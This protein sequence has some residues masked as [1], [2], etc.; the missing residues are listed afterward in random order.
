MSRSTSF[1]KPSRARQSGTLPSSG[2]MM[3]L[4]GAAFENMDTIVRKHIKEPVKVFGVEADVEIACRFLQH[5]DQPDARYLA[6]TLFSA[7]LDQFPKCPRLHLLRAH[8]IAT[9]ELLPFDD[10]WHSLEAAKAMKPAF[11]TRF[12]IFFE[13][14]AMEQQRR[15]ED[16]LASTLNVAGYAEFNSMEADAQRYHLETIIAIK[17]LWQYMRNEK[18][19]SASL[20]FLLERIEKNR[21]MSIILYKKILSKYPRSKQ[22]LR[23]YSNFLLR[24][25][26]DTEQAKKLLGRAEEIENDEARYNSLA[27]ANDRREDEEA[28]ESI[29]PRVT[30]YAP[31]EEPRMEKS[32]TMS[33]D[34]DIAVGEDAGGRARRR[35]RESIGRDAIEGEIGGGMQRK[36]SFAHP[37]MYPIPQEQSQPEMQQPEVVR[38]KAGSVVPSSVS[39]QR[40]ARQQRF[41]KEAITRR[42]RAPIV[43]FHFIMNLGL[44]ALIAI[45]SVGFALGIIA[46]ENITSALDEAY[47]RCRPRVT[48]MRVNKAV[49]ELQSTVNRLLPTNDVESTYQTMLVAMSSIVQGIC[50]PILL[51][52]LQKYHLNDPASIVMTVYRGSTAT[53]ELYNPF[54]LGQALSDRA[55]NIMGADMSTIVESTDA[56]FFMDNLITINQAY[57]ATSTEGITNFLSA[58][59]ANQ[60]SMIGLLVALPVACIL[61]VYVVYRPMIENVYNKQV[62][63]LSLLSGVSRKYVNEMIE[64]FEIECENIMEELDESR[65]SAKL[66]GSVNSS[67]PPDSLMSRHAPKKQLKQV[68][69]CFLL[70]AAPGSLMFVP[71]LQQTNFATQAAQTIKGLSDISFEIASSTAMAVEIAANDSTAFLPHYP[72]LWTKFFQENYQNDLANLVSGN[73]ANQPSIF[74]FP[75]VQ[76]ALKIGNMCFR[77]N[78]IC[79]SADRV[80]NASFGFTEA[81]VT[82]P[83]LDLAS[84]WLEGLQQFTALSN[85]AQTFSSP[86]LSLIR[87]INDD[88]VDGAKD[89]NDFIVKDI[90][91]KTN[92]ARAFSILAFTI[93]VAVFALSYLLVNRRLII[94]FH[95]QMSSCLWLVFSLPPEIMTALPDLK[96]FVESGGA[97]LPGHTQG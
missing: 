15:Q 62:L 7:G 12:S 29:G 22:T 49:R 90:T 13:E 18:Q 36:I 68:A 8:Y 81:L 89:L 3:D 78:G 93:S 79:D 60:M 42:L 88:L 31:G 44:F 10:I 19:A 43:R 17:A 51:P 14:C 39:S 58:I 94:S 77:S 57:D 50:Q 47:A 26:D 53:F 21:N 82:G 5:N 24:A 69:I 40:E 1:K 64:G 11:D 32:A 92:Q 83:Y 91:S 46:Y 25:T 6:N 33:D 27:V 38:K 95:G 74:S 4:E 76:S 23:R 67:L 97:L 87:A 85:E 35:R 75:S 84:T 48:A 66:A 56:R 70:F 34:D 55:D 20:P 9:Y 16:L 37:A 59:S 71:A 73:G 72:S 65:A 80:Y 2:D 54:T 61:L 41:L 30:V 52:V 86:Y 96:R 28:M 45:L 63:V